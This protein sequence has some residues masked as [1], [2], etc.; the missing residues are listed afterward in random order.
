[1]YSLTNADQI[2]TE[3]RLYKGK[4]YQ[5]L[6][7]NFSVHFNNKWPRSFF[8]AFHKFPK[9]NNAPPFTAPLI[10]LL[11]SSTFHYLIYSRTLGLIMFHLKIIMPVLRD[12][13]LCRKR[14]VQLQSCH[15]MMKIDIEIEFHL[16][17]L[18]PQIT[19]KNGERYYSTGS[20]RIDLL[21]SLVNA[22][23]IMLENKRKESNRLEVE[24]VSQNSR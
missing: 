5:V 7:F 8:Q 10:F 15:L 16:I 17:I 23:P 13:L 12:L 2:N 24:Q 22:F 4:V 20:F 1:M 18:H 21:Y 19:C 6:L 3:K 11:I 14:I 9:F